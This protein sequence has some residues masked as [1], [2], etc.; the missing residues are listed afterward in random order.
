MAEPPVDGTCLWFVGATRADRTASDD[1]V[2]TIPRL[3][4]ARPE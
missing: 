1:T 4:R 2:V 3:G